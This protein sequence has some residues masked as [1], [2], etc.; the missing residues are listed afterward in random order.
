MPCMPK[1]GHAPN[2]VITCHPCDGTLGLFRYKSEG[3][4]S[5]ICQVRQLTEPVRTVN[6]LCMC[7]SSLPKNSQN[8][9]LFCDVV[10]N[11]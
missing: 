2:S 3:Q 9:K 10:Y 7:A 1:N 6:R 8:G 4:I 5:I 11:A